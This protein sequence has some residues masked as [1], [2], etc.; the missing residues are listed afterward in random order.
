MLKKSYREKSPS[1]FTSL[2]LLIEAKQNNYRLKNG[3]E[4][5]PFETENLIIEKK[6]KKANELDLHPAINEHETSLAIDFPSKEEEEILYY[7]DFYYQTKGPQIM[8]EIILVGIAITLFFKLL[9][10]M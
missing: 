6:T 5:C 8:S 1:K 9:G 4:L 10:V 3:L 2:D 7:P